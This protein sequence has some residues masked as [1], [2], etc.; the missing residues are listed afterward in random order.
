[1]ARFRTTNSKGEEESWKGLEEV[2]L[3]THAVFYLFAII[4]FFM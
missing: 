4:N 2:A 3:N 1:M